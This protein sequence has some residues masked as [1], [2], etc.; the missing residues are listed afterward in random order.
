[1]EL[2]AALWTERRRTRTLERVLVSAGVLAADAV[3]QW[4]D[5]ATAAEADREELERWMQ[6][7]FGPLAEIGPAV[8]AQD[9]E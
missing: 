1:M 3:E 9:G 7:L 5:E 6:R 2:G 4:V 8:P